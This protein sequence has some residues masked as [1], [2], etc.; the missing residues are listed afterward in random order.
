MTLL[1]RM[2]KFFAI[3]G[4]FPRSA[5]ASPCAVSHR[6]VTNPHISEGQAGNKPVPNRV[7]P[8][9][10]L[11]EQ[12]SASLVPGQICRP[13]ALDRVEVHLGSE[14]TTI[15]AFHFVQ[16]CNLSRSERRHACEPIQVFPTAVER[17]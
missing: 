7:F 14:L 2:E 8:S 17:L 1:R 3:A 12:S 6:T 11:T 16:E 15:V 9:L 4:H 13:L 5:N 10:M